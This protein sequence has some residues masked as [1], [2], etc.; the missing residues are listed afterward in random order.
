MTSKGKP[1]KDPAARRL[2]LSS[3]SKITRYTDQ[4]TVQW[5]LVDTGGQRILLVRDQTILAQWPV[6]TAAVG[7][8]NREDSG[9]TPP[10]VHRV[11]QKI[12]RDK[13]AGTVFESRQPTGEIWTPEWNKDLEWQNKDLILSRI[14]VLDGLESGLNQGPGVDSRQRFIYIHGT[15]REDLIGQAVS[16]GCVRME[17]QNM[18]DLFDQVEEGD[19]L[20]IT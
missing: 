11:A 14:L 13:P 12:G 17:N 10:G 19:L 7:L 3:H 8:D 6:S 1:G 20:V 18:I 4:E 16:H 9:G 5:L 2:V 15:N